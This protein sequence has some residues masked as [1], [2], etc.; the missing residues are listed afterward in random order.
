MDQ[1]LRA[2][3]GLAP[4]DPD[5]HRF[6]AGSA[7]LDLL[8][9]PADGVLMLVD[10]AHWMDSAS[11]DVLAFAARRLSG[12]PVAMICAARGGVP[13]ARLER[14][15]QELRLGPLSAADASKLLAAR[16]GMGGP[17]GLGGLQQEHHVAVG[18][19]VGRFFSSVLFENLLRPQ[20][21]NGDRHLA[22]AP[23]VW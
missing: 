13:P 11:L 18:V 22:A 9:G 20:T 7:L 3:I 12:K 1:R 10:D 17:V 21:C 23:A 2:S 14:C 6:L 19:E 16:C 4:I 15:V 5:E 8:A